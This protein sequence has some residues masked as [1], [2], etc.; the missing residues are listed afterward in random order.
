MNKMQM[1]WL[2]SSR[3]ENVSLRRSYGLG[4]FHDILPH[5]EI[6]KPG[7]LISCASS[8]CSYL[9]ATTRNDEVAYQPATSPVQVI[10]GISVGRD[11]MAQ[12]DATLMIHR[13]VFEVKLQLFM[14]PFLLGK[15]SGTFQGEHKVARCRRKIL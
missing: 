6:I 11:A 7:H 13:G 14:N 3:L 8:T 10:E 9:G 1:Q 15:D 12:F 4:T 5:C 2:P